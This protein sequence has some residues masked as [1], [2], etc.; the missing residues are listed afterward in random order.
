M[1]FPLLPS[2]RWILFLFSFWK[3]IIRKNH[4][5]HIAH[6]YRYIDWQQL[7]IVQTDVLYVFVFCSKVKLTN[8]SKKK[9]DSTQLQLHKTLSQH[10][11]WPSSSV[12][13]SFVAFS[14]FELKQL[15]SVIG[16]NAVV[17]QCNVS[18]RGKGGNTCG[19]TLR[20]CQLSAGDDKVGNG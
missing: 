17:C 12:T 19:A 7:L 6:N 3:L 16:K 13:L 2:F 1:F 10:E 15:I 5:I 11:T 8:S 4:N 14:V 18:K 9:W 20:I